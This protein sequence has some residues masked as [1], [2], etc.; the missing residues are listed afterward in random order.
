[1]DLLGQQNNIPKPESKGKKTVL[2]LL[3]L[4]VVLLVVV[5]GLIYFL[6]VSQPKK[7]TL[8]VDTVT[9]DMIDGLII[10]DAD[11]GKDYVSLNDIATLIGYQYLRGEY[12]EYREISTKGYLQSTNQIIGF[13]SGSNKIYKTTPNVNID[14]QYFDIKN[15]VIQNNDK[16]YIALEDF[17]TAC[18]AIIKYSSDKNKIDIFTANYLIEN[19]YGKMVID[20]GTYKYVDKDYENQKALMHNMLVV[21]TSE[22]K[23]GEDNTYGVISTDMKQIITP[24]F[25]EIKYDEY[26]KNF[27]V[28]GSDNGYGVVSGDGKE[29]IVE[30]KY[31]SV[32][33][34]NYN[35]VLYEVELNNKYGVINKEGKLIANIEYDKLG[36]D[37]ENKEYNSTLVIKNCYENKDGLV[38]YKNYGY[39]IIDIETGREIAPPTKEVSKIY[40]KTNEKGEN[41]YFVEFKGKEYDLSVYIEYVNTIPVNVKSDDSTNE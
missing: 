40:S 20:E 38:V 24:K 25:K 3:I 36:Y 31:D 5:I 35:P 23:D 17:A 18:D 12:K 4:S 27:I 11:T 8:S 19:D 1:M 29:V 32:R 39:G 6:Q 30:V 16:L 2:T 41:E 10:Y 13:E 34:I 26:T 33:I 15:K 7:Q 28:K 14:F 21:G 37:S 22:K 9:K